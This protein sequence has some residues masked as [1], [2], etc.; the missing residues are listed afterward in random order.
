[1]K[2]IMNFEVHDKRLESAS[3]AEALHADEP[4]DQDQHQDAEPL[5]SV[6]PEDGVDRR[7]P[8]L[9]DSTH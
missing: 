1:M 3:R 5:P 6:H 4:D 8:V 7:V 9:F 2:C